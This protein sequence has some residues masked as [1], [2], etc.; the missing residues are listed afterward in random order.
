MN[1]SGRFT[2]PATPSSR[3]TSSTRTTIPC[4]D[5][6]WKMYDARHRTVRPDGY[7]ARMGR[8]HSRR[9]TKSI[10]KRSK[11]TAFFTSR[12][13]RSH[14]IRSPDGAHPRGGNAMSAALLEL[15]KRMAS[16]GDGAADAQRNHAQGP[17]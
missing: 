12:K 17:P 1:A 8:P 11:R 13:N 6:V 2:S 10:A 16:C 4:I 5:P 15:Q 7:A 3:S 14:P 9:S